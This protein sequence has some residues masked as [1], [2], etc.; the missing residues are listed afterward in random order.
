MDRYELAEATFLAPSDSK[1]W[2]LRLTVERLELYGADD[3]AA[4]M[5]AAPSA[6]QRPRG[7]QKLREERKHERAELQATKQALKSAVALAVREAPTSTKLWDLA[8]ALRQS[9]MIS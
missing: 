1:R 2:P 4:T 5:E 9:G 8:N 7:L 3:D 6:T